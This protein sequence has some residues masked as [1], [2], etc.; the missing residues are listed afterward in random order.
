M[1]SERDLSSFAHSLMFTPKSPRVH[2]SG[3]EV[4]YSPG[5]PSEQALCTLYL[6]RASQLEHILEATPGIHGKYGAKY[7]TK[8]EIGV[9]SYPVTL[10]TSGDWHESHPYFRVGRY[11]VVHP[12]L[13]FYHPHAMDLLSTDLTFSEMVQRSNELVFLCDNRHPSLHLNTSLDASNYYFPNTVG[14]MVAVQELGSLLAGRTV[15]DVGSRNGLLAVVAL[16]EGAASALAIE[17]DRASVSLL[18]KE[19]F[20]WVSPETFEYEDRI[21]INLALNRAESSVEVIRSTLGSVPVRE[22][23]GGVAIFNFPDY[24]MGFYDDEHGQLC[25]DNPRRGSRASLGYDRTK[26]TFRES[27]IGDVTQKFPGLEYVIASGGSRLRND[28]ELM[29]DR[30][31]ELI[32]HA[33]KLGWHLEQRIAVAHPV[34][35]GS[36]DS[37]LMRWKDPLCAADEVAEFLTF[38]FKRG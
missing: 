24:G 3:E 28:P 6:S 35:R 13:G 23:A 4:G 36:I 10:T 19:Q 32:S 14:C 20:S 33:E 9:H 34:G 37:A 21:S 29:I 15:V 8:V 12:D 16:R 11:V 30:S 22:L 7:N 5:T 27:L 1:Y 18:V 31:E 25:T 2:T 17:N 26:G 38:I